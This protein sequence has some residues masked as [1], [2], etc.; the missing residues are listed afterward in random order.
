MPII[1]TRWEVIS[2]RQILC[3][4]RPGTGKA[5]GSIHCRLT[6]HKGQIMPFF[7]IGK[8]PPEILEGYLSQIPIEDDRVVL[9]PG[10][11]MDASVIDMG[12]RYLVAT[13]DPVTFAEKRIGWYAVNVNANDTA[14]MGGK[15]GWFLGTPLLPPDRP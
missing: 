15:P 9:G 1:R 2:Q 8:L 10:L 5:A 7:Q 4:V 11:G 6:L 14:V 3:C 12:D 13:M